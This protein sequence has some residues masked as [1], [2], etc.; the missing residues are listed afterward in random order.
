M[1]AFHSTIA[2]SELFGFVSHA[3]LLFDLSELVRFIRVT[4]RFELVSINVLYHNLCN[5]GIKFIDMS[6][7]IL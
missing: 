1:L 4:L 6:L 2:A 5:H 3:Q 7:S